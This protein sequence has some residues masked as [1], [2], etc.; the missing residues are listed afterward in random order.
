MSPTQPPFES[1]LESLDKLAKRPTDTPEQVEITLKAAAGLGYDHALLHVVNLARRSAAKAGEEGVILLQFADEVRVMLGPGWIQTSP[2]PPW[3]Q[4]KRWLA[5]VGP[6]IRG[7]IEAA[8]DVRPT[9]PPR[10]RAFEMTSKGQYAKE[11]DMWPGVYFLA[12]D[13]HHAVVLSR[14]I[15]DEQPHEGPT[16]FL[17]S[18]SGEVQ[19]DADGN[20][21]FGCIYAFDGA[22][23]T[24]EP[25]EL[26]AFMTSGGPSH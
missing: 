3:D 13:R 6:W 25:A 7:R 23:G 11:E 22:K 21:T 14:K 4:F 20:P 12:N 16:H 18:D 8:T 9:P 19:E 5:A 17:L 1:L 10:R 15:W 24:S 26:I 2:S